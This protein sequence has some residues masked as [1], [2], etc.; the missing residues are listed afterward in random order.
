M[1]SLDPACEEPKL[2]VQAEQVQSEETNPDPDEGKP[3]CITP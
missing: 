2:E 3:R 1:H